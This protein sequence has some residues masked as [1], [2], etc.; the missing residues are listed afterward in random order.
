MRSKSIA[1]LVVASFIL[2]IVATPIPA[3]GVAYYLDTGGNHIFDDDSHKWDEVFLDSKGYR[4][5]GTKLEIVTGGW[6]EDLSAHAISEVTFNGGSSVGDI[7]GFGR[8]T[9]TV[10]SGHIGGSIWT[11][12]SSTVNL[13]GG[14]FGSLRAFGSGV[15]YIHGSNFEVDGISVNY[16]DSLRGYSTNILDPYL[17]EGTI[18]GTLQDGS[19]LNSSYAIYKISACDIIVVPEPATLLLLALGV[20]ILRRTK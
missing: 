4:D 11:D 1:A 17:L 2:L 19:A 15:M 7:W 3:F 14:S 16:G 12:A 13:K 8:S 18:T 5:P 6:V 10:N 20:I 9:I